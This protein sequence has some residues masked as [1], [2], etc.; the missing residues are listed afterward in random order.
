MR[1]FG[2][3]LSKGD[4][5]NKPAPVEHPHYTTHAK[6]VAA[7]APAPRRVSRTER[8]G[9]TPPGDVMQS[10]VDKRRKQIEDAGG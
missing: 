6:E 10:M 9:M 7:P 3:P 2:I 1:L 8:A 4:L 5:K